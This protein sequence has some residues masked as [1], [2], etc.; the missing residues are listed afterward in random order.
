MTLDSATKRAEPL[1]LRQLG[2]RKASLILAITLSVLGCKSAQEEKTPA[3]ETN[4]AFGET[5]AGLATYYDATGGGQCSFPES[6]DDLMVA[7]LNT[8]QFDTAAWC[9]AC[10]EIEGSKGKAIVRIV[11]RCPECEYGHLDLS[12]QAF[13][14]VDDM[15][16][17]RVPLKWKFVSCDISTNMSFHY[18]DGTSQWWVAL[19]VRN[20]RLP[21]KK[22]ELKVD[23]SWVEVQRRIY[24]YFV[25]ES[26][27]ADANPKF[28]VH[29]IDDSMVEVTLPTPASDQVI[30]GSS[31]F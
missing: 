14:A 17:G 24:N 19:Q 2:L 21:V 10:A 27:V 9:G 29:A 30:A 15:S 26:Q 18:K 1:S 13:A 5:V 16:K 4:Q 20:H 31:Q 11:D 8:P 23:D 25:Y 22:V 6:P 28:R 7:A 3:P 12:Q